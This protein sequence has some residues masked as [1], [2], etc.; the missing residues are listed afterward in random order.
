MKPYR[1][2]TGPVR[3]GPGQVLHLSPQQVALRAHNLEVGK[4]DR[5][6]G[7]VPVTVVNAIEFKTGEVIGLEGVS[8]ALAGVLEDADKAPSV[9]ARTPVAEAD[10]AAAVEAEKRRSLEMWQA[11]LPR[12]ATAI[13]EELGLEPRLVAEAL[14]RQLDEPFPEL[15]AVLATQQERPAQD[16]GADGPPK[17]DEKAGRRHK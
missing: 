13:A 10:V 15:A 7:A 17:A 4:P 12:I 9:P 3:F 6:T 1:V 5:R 14:K 11:A 2:V 8:R 16:A